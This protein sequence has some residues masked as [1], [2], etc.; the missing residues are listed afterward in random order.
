MARKKKDSA[1]KPATGTRQKPATQTAGKDGGQAADKKTLIDKLKTA[2]KTN[3]KEGS[4]A[5]SR[6]G[7]ENQKDDKPAKIKP[8]YRMMEDGELEAEWNNRKFVLEEERKKRA[9]QLNTTMAE[10]DDRMMRHRKNPPCPKCGSHPTVCMMRRPGYELRRCR[11]CGHRW[12]IKETD[13]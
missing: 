13:K 8:D 7:R 3:A 6:Q 12:E 9:I 2:L 1:E 10:P 11:Q 5:E 4:D